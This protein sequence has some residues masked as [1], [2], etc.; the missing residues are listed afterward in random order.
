MRFQR[1]FPGAL[2]LAGYVLFF[3]GCH[4]HPLTDYRPLIKAG[5]DSSYTERLKTL[6]TSDEEIAQVVKLRQSHISDDM[7]VA[8]VSAA[9]THQHPFSSA[10]SANSLAGAGY[11]DLQIMEIASADKLDAIS[12][13]AVMLRLIG[14]SDATVQLVL[15]RRLQGLPVLSSAEIAKLKNTGLTERQI[16]ERIN[17]GMTDAQ[18]DHEIYV[19]ETIRNHS[20]TGF[21]R[22]HG[23]R[24]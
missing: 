16:V 4:T 9:H 10:D 3:G 11:S 23:R 13:D 18:A 5:M 2:V 19:R 7:S 21:V 17:Q 12:G 1:S 24:R 22:A 8:L 15:D 20:N 6:N 14:F